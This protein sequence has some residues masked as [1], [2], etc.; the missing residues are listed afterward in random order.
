MTTKHGLIGGDLLGEHT[1]KV[2][3]PHRLVE[4]WADQA[5][6]Y[7]WN[8]H[9]QYIPDTNHCVFYLMNDRDAVFLW[10]WMER[11]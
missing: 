7:G 2:L 5:K 9:V 3:D 1:L 6:V 10:I 11:T 4:H 8:T